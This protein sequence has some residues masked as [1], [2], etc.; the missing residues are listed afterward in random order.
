M[1]E[2]YVY[3]KE[4]Q[5]TSAALKHLIGSDHGFAE[6][7]TPPVQKQ[8]KLLVA[9]DGTATLDRVVLWTDRDPRTS[10]LIDDLARWFAIDGEPPN[11]VNHPGFIAFM[12]KRFPAF[13]GVSPATISARLK[14]FSEK[15]VEWF[16][17]FQDTIEWFGATTDGW[18]SDA[19]QHYRT[20]T[21]HF[22]IPNTWTLVGLNLETA[23][24]GGSDDSIKEFLLGVIAKY[25][26]LVKKIVAIT[27]DNA[28]AEVAGVRLADLHRVAC[29]CHLLNL[30]M[31]L[32]I[33]PGKPATVRKPARASSPVFEHLSKLQKFVQKLHN[34]P[35]LMATLVQELSEWARR[36]QQAAV[37]RVPTKPNNTRWNS[38][39]MMVE[40]SFPIRDSIDEV[41]RKHAVTYNL[42]RFSALDWKVIGQ[43]A[44]LLHPF[45]VVSTYMEGE[46]YPT[47]PEYLGHLAGA[48][49]K[50]FYNNI[51]RHAQ[52]EACVQIVLVRV[53]DDIGRRLWR[54]ENDVTLTGLLLHPVFKALAPPAS[55]IP[56]SA[57]VPESILRY[58]F[59]DLR[60]RMVAAALRELQRLGIKPAPVVQAAEEDNPLAFI[61][62][63]YNHAQQNS[64]RPEHEINAWLGMPIVV[65]VKLTEYWEREGTRWPLLQQLARANFVAQASSA[66]SERVWSAADDVSGGDRASV[67]PET[68]NVQLVLK[69]NTAVQAEILG[70]SVFE[71]LQ[72]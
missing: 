3:S 68:L 58:F 63:G 67:A 1:R 72:K 48:C 45:K 29:G 26:L 34:A 28:N 11:L 54:T 42:D 32:V 14:A 52:L 64:V 17:A 39:C 46:R 31:K 5:S 25:K 9:Q 24:C 6:D 20:F 16:M 71:V 23:L 38:V 33:D 55:G 57:Y 40:S 15:F 59:K 51:A 70:C 41:L 43:L 69:K 66:A 36:N 19:K 10:S 53:R 62:Q 56:E 7:G 37:P 50:A 21:L 22:F 13:P 60:Q 18:S 49:F 27:T 4:T 61:V 30:S 8:R 65:G 44:W 12:A 35:L 47:A 2:K